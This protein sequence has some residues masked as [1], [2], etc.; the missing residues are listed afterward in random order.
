LAPTELRRF[1]DRFGAAALLDRE[2]RAYADGGLGYLRMSDAE[3]A[4]RIA[5]DQR[6]LRLPLARSG[7]LLSVGTDTDA[8]KQM[9]DAERAS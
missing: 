9:V 4:E 1:L 7:R 6:L 8:W 5:A 2:S 3:M